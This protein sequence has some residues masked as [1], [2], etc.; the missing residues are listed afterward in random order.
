MPH[1]HTK[2][3]QH[4]ATISG[5]IIRTDG[6]EP[7]ILLHR[8]KLLRRYFQFGGHVELHEDPWQALTHELLEESGYDMDQLQVLQPRV[9]YTETNPRI[10]RHPLPFSSVTHPFADQ[11]HYHSDTTYAFTAIEESRHPIGKDEADTLELL[12]A[13]QIRAIPD[14]DIYPE[15]RG[16]ALFALETLLKEWEPVPAK[17]F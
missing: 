14:K 10:V 8:H 13:A 2:P 5:F 3:G 9:R 11:D 12:T 17:T 15:I 4:D 6:D 1:V 16:M 7:R